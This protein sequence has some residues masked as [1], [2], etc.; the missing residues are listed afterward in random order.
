MFI[1]VNYFLRWW[2]RTKGRR[3]GTWFRRF[4]ASN[5][6]NLFGMFFDAS[7]V[8][9]LTTWSSKSW[10]I[11]NCINLLDINCF[12]SRHSIGINIF[13]ECLNTIRWALVTS[14]QSFISIYGVTQGVC[15]TVPQGSLNVVKRVDFGILRYMCEF[16][17]FEFF[18]KFVVQIIGFCLYVKSG[19]KYEAWSPESVLAPCDGLSVGWSIWCVCLTS[20]N[21]G[22]LA[23]FE[24]EVRF[25]LA[26]VRRARIC[27]WPRTL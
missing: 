27:C 26:Y 13:Y 18:F 23:N 11:I 3:W 20:L 4:A 16:K 22:E 9:L 8:F 7:E 5:A 25:H 12:V 24:A 15:T 6:R 2:P 21:I 14:V 10:T 19:K 17:S 1:T